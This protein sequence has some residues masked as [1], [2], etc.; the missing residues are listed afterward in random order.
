[1]TREQYDVAV[2]QETQ[3]FTAAETEAASGGYPGG[4]PPFRHSESPG[5]S[6]SSYSGTSHGAPSSI[7]P[8]MNTSPY[9]ENYGYGSGGSQ[10]QS[11]QPEDP[12][13][14]NGT[15]SHARHGGN[16]EAPRA[17]RQSYPQDRYQGTG[18]YPAEDYQGIGRHQANGYPTGGYSTGGYPGASHQ[19]NANGYRGNGHR[20]PYDPRADYRRL[21]YPG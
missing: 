21:T 9:G 12:R 14:H 1:M 18:S 13:R 10:A 17:A 4:M 5:R 6:P 11:A 19:G 8:A 15:R 3:T 7:T 20:A 16:D 2:T